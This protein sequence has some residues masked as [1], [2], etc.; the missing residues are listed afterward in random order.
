M[1]INNNLQDFLTD[2]ANAIR[3]KEGS[4]ETINSQDFST[5]IREISTGS[6]A[7]GQVLKITNKF[8]G[9]LIGGPNYYF[10]NS[11]TSSP[12]VF[13]TYTFEGS[14][15]ASCA[16]IGGYGSLSGYERFPNA[17]LTLYGYT[18]N[19]NTVNSGLNS[20]GTYYGQFLLYTNNVGQV[21]LVTG[22]SRSSTASL[23]VMFIAYDKDGNCDIDYFY[24]QSGWACICA[25][26]L[27]TL[28]DGNTKKIQDINYEDE[29]LVWN[30]D[31]GCLDKSKP[32]WIK[33]SEKANWYRL[34]TFS[35][36]ITLQ[37]TGSY[38]YSHRIFNVTDQRFDYLE[39]S[40]G[41]EIY[42]RDGIV[43]LLSCEEFTD[44]VIE[45][46][47]IIT[48]YHMNLF[49]NGILTSCRYNNLYS[50]G[51]DMKFIKEDRFQGKPEWKVYQEKFL[52]HPEIPGQYIYG[53]RLLEWEGS[54]NDT[55]DYI[56]RLEK[57]R[58]RA[59]EFE[60]N[61]QLSENIEEVNVG[62][63][64][65]EGK[66][67]GYKLYMPGQNNHITLADK[68]GSLLELT[69][70]SL[71]GFSRTLE[72]AGWIKFTS[73]FLSMDPTIPTITE[74]QKEV[75]CKFLDCLKSREINTI[76][77]GSIL[78]EKNDIDYIKLMPTRDLVT[79]MKQW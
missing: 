33:R 78:S 29:L 35:N 14:P 58:K 10:S 76:S 25:D 7:I 46:Y 26:T 28:A 59:E 8:D 24:M 9:A 17:Y 42:T 61:F 55:A 74:A 21:Y 12:K 2:I 15:V 65:P 40:V 50:I 57:T 64:S 5:R 51:K 77:L 6:K 27:I 11:T 69:E 19:T 70:E 48:D 30:F 49:A 68:I 38:P 1:A 62:W 60:E 34:S 43:T 31:K 67:Y 53:L 20:T 47:N 4:T 66:T 16:I 32:L 71:G 18:T 79:K 44:R 13:H 73:K 37:T 22:G 23:P 72:K 54:M 52:D 63:I 39:D 75:L 36:G 45:F 56:K 41:K 3:E